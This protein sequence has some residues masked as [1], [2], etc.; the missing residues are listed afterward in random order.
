MPIILEAGTCRVCGCTKERPCSD[1]RG[2]TCGWFDAE[3]TLCDAFR[4]VA[5]TP[6]EVLITMTPATFFLEEGAEI[7]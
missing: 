2:Y 6:L 1:D 7:R 4:C 5:V 3:R